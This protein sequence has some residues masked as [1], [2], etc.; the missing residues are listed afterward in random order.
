MQPVSKIRKVA[1]RS[2]GS[3]ANHCCVNGK[4]HLI[5]QKAL[6]VNAF[7]T[8]FHADPTQMNPSC[9]LLYEN[10]QSTKLYAIGSRKMEAACALFVIEPKC[11]QAQPLINDYGFPG[12]GNQPS[13]ALLPRRKDKSEAFFHSW[14]I[15]TLAH[16]I[17]LDTF[18]FTTLFIRLPFN[19]TL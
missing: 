5:R 1:R 4:S 6:R 10:P 14:R 11:S 3:R 13:I 12:I 17:T 16:S 9:K 15:C 18:L 7:P 8:E 2:L 19:Y